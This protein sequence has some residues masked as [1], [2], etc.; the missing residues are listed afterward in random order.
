M[1]D[2]DS[3]ADALGRLFDLEAQALRCG[4]LSGLEAGAEAK[5]ALAT[6][7]AAA[8]APDPAV[9]RRLHAAA[10]RNA[11]LI[12]AAAEGVRAARDRLAA[13]ARAAGGTDTYDGGGQRQRLA[14]PA[15]ARFERRA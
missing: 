14:N 5:I 13:L 3:P 12:A 9:L 2:R 8:T 1:A 7:L 15:A 11:C 4:D 10:A 6:R